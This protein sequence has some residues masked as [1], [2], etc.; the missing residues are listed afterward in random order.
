[1]S[2]GLSRGAGTCRSLLRLRGF[3]SSCLLSDSALAVR[4]LR[5]VLVL[6]FLFM[7]GVKHF[8]SMLSCSERSGLP[9]MSF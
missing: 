3:F 7:L 1:M 8:L 9:M 2:L 4:L 6:L 5:V